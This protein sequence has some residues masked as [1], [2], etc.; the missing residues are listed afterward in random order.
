LIGYN[1][2][3]ARNVLRT[4]PNISFNTH[5][6]SVKGPLGHGFVN[7][8]H[9]KKNSEDGKGQVIFTWTVNTARDMRWAIRNN[10]D[11]ILT[12][13]PSLSKQICDSWDDEY[14]KEHDADDDKV[15]LRERLHLTLW[16]FWFFSFSWL[17]PLLY[18]HLQR[19]MREKPGVRAEIKGSSS[20]T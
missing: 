1:V 14:A 13:D 7:A 5:W 8:V 19:F 17:F 4:V 6:K 20:R 9:S 15:T 11:A 16:G 18:P 12:D 10:F 2:V 3:G